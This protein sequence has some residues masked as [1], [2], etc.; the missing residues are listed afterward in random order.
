M[1]FTSPMRHALLNCRINSLLECVQVYTTS[2]TKSDMA[3]RFNL[4]RK[5]ENNSQIIITGHHFR[6]LL[7]CILQS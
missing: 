3:T 4:L 1:K 7:H 6:D 5:R 2:R